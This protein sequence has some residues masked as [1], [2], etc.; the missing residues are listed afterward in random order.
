MQVRQLRL[1]AEQYGLRPS[2]YMAATG[3]KDG[4]TMTN[5]QPTEGSC[6]GSERAGAKSYLKR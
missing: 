6:K 5:E 3:R 4:Q 2:A 1:T